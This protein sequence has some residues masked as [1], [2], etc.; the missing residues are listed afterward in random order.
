MCTNDLYT[1]K[2]LSRINCTLACSTL[3]YIPCQ[4]YMDRKI[5]ASVLKRHHSQ[6]SII[7][8]RSILFPSN[9]RRMQSLLQPTS[10]L[11]PLIH[12][13]FV[14]KVLGIFSVVSLLAVLIIYFTYYKRSKLRAAQSLKPPMETNGHSR[15]R[16]NS[17]YS[18]SDYNYPCMVCEE[19][20]SIL[21]GSS[22]N[23]IKK[24]ANENLYKHV[25][26]VQANNVASDDV[27]F[28]LL[29]YY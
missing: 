19:D 3:G 8:Y 22:K 4:N 26:C 28:E 27:S 16:Q 11:T 17:S 9:C 14:Q 23:P 2:D 25:E 1:C 24:K 15:A 7:E 12:S 21:I 18:S 6:S 10:P 20:G 29:A 5:C 13:K